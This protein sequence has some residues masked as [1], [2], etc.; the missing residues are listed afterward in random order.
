MDSSFHFLSSSTYS[1]L[2]EVSLVW[3]ILEAQST[4]AL[5]SYFLEKP[6]LHMIQSLALAAVGTGN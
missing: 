4:D 3:I 1:K 6:L 5:T 2:Y